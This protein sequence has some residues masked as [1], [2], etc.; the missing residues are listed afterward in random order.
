MAILAGRSNEMITPPHPSSPTHITDETSM[1]FQLLRRAELAE[2]VVTVYYCFIHGA[3]NKLFATPAGRTEIEAERDF[4][5]FAECGRE[6]V[7]YVN[8]NPVREVLRL[9]ALVDV[10]SA[11]GGDEGEFKASRGSR[12]RT[13]GHWGEGYV[14]DGG[15]EF[16]SHLKL[17]FPAK[18][19]AF[20]LCEYRLLVA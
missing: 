3:D 7:D 1:A 19:G 18:V 15:M 12:G 13:G 16:G 4:I 14:V 6:R 5:F 10:D 11:V 20:G 2:P 17:A 9:S 8:C